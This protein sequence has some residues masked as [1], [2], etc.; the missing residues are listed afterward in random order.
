M[1]DI[2]NEEFE[3]Y[4]LEREGDENGDK[5]WDILRTRAIMDTR[6][7]V[8]DIKKSVGELAEHVKDTD[9]KLAQHIEDAKDNPSLVWLLRNRTKKTL[10]T[11]GSAFLSGVLFLFILFRM[12]EILV[13]FEKLVEGL[14]P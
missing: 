2:I 13:G 3:A 10:A 1:T 8:K 9:E 12:L 4:I 6:N 5:R 7:G 11:S 14:V